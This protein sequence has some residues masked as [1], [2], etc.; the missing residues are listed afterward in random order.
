MVCR[1]AVRVRVS[2]RV[3]VELGSKVLLEA[4]YILCLVIIH[5]PERHKISTS[6]ET[7]TATMAL[8]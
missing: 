8:P 7:L 1:V 4:T 6:Q 5:D 3:R 2:V